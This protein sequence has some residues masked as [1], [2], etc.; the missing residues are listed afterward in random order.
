MDDGEQ[1]FS[2]T[3]HNG[4]AWFISESADFH[5]CKSSAVL[6]LSTSVPC[7]YDYISRPEL[8]PF[9]YRILQSQRLILLSIY[10]FSLVLFWVW[11]LS[12]FQAP[13][14][15][16]RFPLLSPEGHHPLPRQTCTNVII[17]GDILLHSSEVAHSEH[18]FGFP[19][20]FYCFVSQVLHILRTG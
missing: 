1:R 13:D 6:P 7:T 18:R 17:V 9:V 10:Y 5:G 14:S 3:K 11:T 8:L 4:I 16:E 15:R 19:R 2:Q 20:G 12:E